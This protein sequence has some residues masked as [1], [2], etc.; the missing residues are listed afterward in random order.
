MSD[1]PQARFVSNPLIV[2]ASALALGIL[3]GHSL[4]QHRLSL[5]LI[6]IAVGLVLVIVC[7]WFLSNA[8]LLRATLSVVAALLCAG[9]VLSLIDSR[10]VAPNR[11]ARLQDEGIIAPGE[12]VELTGVVSGEPEPAP[13]SFYL[14]FKAERIRFKGVE[15]DASGTVFLLAPVR[16]QQVAREYDALELRHGARRAR[17][18]HARSRRQLSQSG[19]LAVH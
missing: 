15:R 4:G 1:L 11:I 16:E 10:S 8:K 19:R 3:A 14:T 12:P 7:V 13:Q 2:L 5:L 17:N 18:D 6:S 9:F